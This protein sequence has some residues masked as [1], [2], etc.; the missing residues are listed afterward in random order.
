MTTPFTSSFCLADTPSDAFEVSVLRRSSHVKRT[1]MLVQHFVLRE[2]RSEKL[3]YAI[4]VISLP[5]KTSI[6]SK[7]IGAESVIEHDIYVCCVA[8]KIASRLSFGS[9]HRQIEQ[10]RQTYKQ[11]CSINAAGVQ[12]TESIA[13]M[14]RR[15]LSRSIYAALGCDSVF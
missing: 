9:L 1:Q 15:K 6:S 7:D 5:R 14:A 3:V 2:M 13:C 4:F 8:E 10:N 12:Y 11:L